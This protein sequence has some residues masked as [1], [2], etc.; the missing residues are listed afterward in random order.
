MTGSGNTDK[1]EIPETTDGTVRRFQTDGR[2]LLGIAASIVAALMLTTMDAIAFNLRLTYGVIEMQLIRN[3]S[4][5]VFLVSLMLLRRERFVPW[6]GGASIA[7]FRGITI[8]PIG[9][10]FFSSFKLLDQ[11]SATALIFTY[12]LMLTVLATVFL[13]ERAG[14]WRWGA[15]LIGFAGV[16]AVQVALWLAK[17]GEWALEDSGRPLWLTA[18]YALLPVAAAVMFSVNM[19]SLRFMPKGVPAISITYVGGIASLLTILPVWVLF[20]ERIPLD[21][22]AHWWQ[23]GLMGVV[24]IGAAQALNIAYRSAPAAVVGSLEY[25]A[26]IF[27]TGLA[28]FTQSLIP[29]AGIWFGVALIMTGGIVTGWRESVHARRKLS[30]TD[31]EAAAED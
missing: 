12:P 25:V 28:W 11:G 29:P 10:L 1:P 26:I 7:V 9:F 23:F 20:G 17:G 15:L 18:T 14:V 6:F 4:A 31:G 22:A 27:A 21:W 30:R 3:V 2:L 19:I 5:M 8:V 24:A 13:G 16:V